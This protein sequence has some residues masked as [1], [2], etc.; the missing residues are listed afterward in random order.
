[1]ALYQELVYPGTTDRMKY[2]GQ[3]I[4]IRLCGD[5]RFKQG[6]IVNQKHQKDREPAPAFHRTNIVSATAPRQLK[7]NPQPLQYDCP[8][9]IQVYFVWHA[10]TNRGLGGKGLRVRAV[11]GS[12]MIRTNLA[13]INLADSSR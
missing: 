6:D 12:A 3:R 7:L 13:Q 2:A 11:M 4:Q 9:V 8:I 1:M 10:I 5:P